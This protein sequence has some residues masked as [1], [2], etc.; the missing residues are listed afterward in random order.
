M[1][2]IATDAPIESAWT[3]ADT[4]RANKYRDAILRAI[5][6]GHEDRIAELFA[7]FRGSEEF[8]A[9]VW[10]LLPAPVRNYLREPRFGL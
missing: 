1:T 9:V 2:L 5:N 7:E 8:T 10:S 6:D 4:L 3:L